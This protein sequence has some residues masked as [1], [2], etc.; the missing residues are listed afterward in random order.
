MSTNKARLTHR[1]RVVRDVVFWIAVLFII[2]MTVDIIQG[3]LSHL[4]GVGNVRG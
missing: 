1:G 4:F 3:V 2:V